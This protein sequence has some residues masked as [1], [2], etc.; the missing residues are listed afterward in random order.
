M[1]A[2]VRRI[3]DSISIPSTFSRILQSAVEIPYF[4][5][6]QAGSNSWDLLRFINFRKPSCALPDLSWSS[7]CPFVF[8]L[9]IALVFLYSRVFVFSSVVLQFFSALVGFLCPPT[10]SWVFLRFPGLSCDIIFPSG[11]LMGPFGL[12]LQR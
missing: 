1:L 3:V 11:L 5:A 6:C 9:F 10:R 7:V 8:A 12:S 4:F 2:W